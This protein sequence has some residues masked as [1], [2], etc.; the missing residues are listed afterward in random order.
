MSNLQTTDDLPTQFS[1]PAAWKGAELFTRD[2]WQIHL[3]QA[4]LDDLQQ[5]LE[6]ISRERL[7]QEHITPARFP[8]PHLG[9]VLQQIQQQ[10]ETGSGACQLKRLPVENYSAS[11]LEILF[12]LI[13]VHIGTPV[14]Q[15]AS[16]DKIFHVRDEGFQVGQKE[17]RGPNTRKRLS[18]HTDRC[19]VI[20]FL[21]L[22]QALSGG[23]NQLVSSVSVFNEMRQRFPELTKTLMQPFY[24]LRHNVDTGNQKP[25]CQQ[26]VFSVQDGHF[27]G[28]F[29]RVLIE[30]AY[31][32]P[33]LPDM[34]PQQREALD[35]LETVAE[36]PELSVTFSQEPGDLLFLNNWVTFHRRDD[37][38]D[39]EESHLKRHL[40]RVWLA[41]PNSRP[42][43]PLFADN[44]GSTAAGAVRG[45]MLP[46]REMDPSNSTGSDSN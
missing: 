36:S 37:F 6:T 15:S 2:D 31:A 7:K 25:F 12:W 19:D 46:T 13:S 33:D 28:S 8:L 3:T 34:S 35:Q 38:E 44:Y 45:G 24:Y 42:L 39:A 29:L 32:S 40:L 17:A 5:A 23:N 43:N 26:P 41:V 14:S 18:F 1:I 20:G 4:H 9:P 27:A 16:G 30:R 22:Q 11:E 21:C 10:L